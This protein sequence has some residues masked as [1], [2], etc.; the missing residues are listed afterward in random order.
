MDCC[1]LHSWAI[2]IPSHAEPQA[3]S[4]SD[5]PQ[6]SPTPHRKGLSQARAARPAAK[7][8]TRKTRAT[9][10]INQP[11]HPS[12]NQPTKQS[13]NLSIHDLL[14]RS[15]SDLCLIPSNHGNPSNFHG[16]DGRTL[17]LS[18]RI[19]KTAIV[20]Q[21]HWAILRQH[22]ATVQDTDVLAPF[23]S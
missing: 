22:E 12:I 7:P 15:M 6:H 2:S 14:C 19:A 23:G 4:L 9:K 21:Q 8:E 11:I 18:L 3:L 1:Q 17:S 13:I 20:L 5:C 10:C 16:F